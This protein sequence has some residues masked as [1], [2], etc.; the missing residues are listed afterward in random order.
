MTI[1]DRVNSLERQNR[2]IRRLA[3]CA[4]AGL[5]CVL[6]MGQGKPKPLPDL[7]AGSL[8]IEDSAGRSRMHL[9]T[10]GEGRA[11]FHMLDKQGHYRLVLTLWPDGTPRLWLQ[12][13]SVDKKIVPAV[14]LG[15]TTDGAFVRLDHQHHGPHRAR[16]ATAKDGTPSITLSDPKGK[17]SWTAPSR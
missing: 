14:V 4:L 16:I 3:S 11:I 13:A 9:Y 12:G 15:A 10:D 7:V 6:L 17:V 2:W 5:A 8:R 1:E